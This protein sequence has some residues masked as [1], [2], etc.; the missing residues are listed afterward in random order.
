MVLQHHTAEFQDRK[1][2]LGVALDI[3]ELLALESRIVGGSIAE[4][5]FR[6]PRIDRSQR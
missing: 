3:E 4:M 1:M 6:V 5:I 2:E